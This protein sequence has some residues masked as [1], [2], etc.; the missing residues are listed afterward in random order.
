MKYT[1]INKKFTTLVA[2]YLAK[3]YMINTATMPGS[4]GERAKVDLTNGTEVIR[5]VLES[6]T[7]YD[8]IH[9]RG[10]KIVVGRAGE[11]DCITPNSPE[12]ACTLWNG[13]LEVLYE[14]CFYQIGR[15]G[16]NFGTKEEA[17]VA[18]QK[19]IERWSK[20]P[21]MSNTEYN[22]IDNPEA[23]HIAAQ[24]LLNKGVAKRIDRNSLKL[25]KRVYKKTH[26]TYLVEYKGKAYSLN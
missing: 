15:R 19:S 18:A 3:G 5:I 2:G 21:T 10:W 6:F 1:E 24:Y 11:Q 20:K 9:L 4:Q 12:D 8:D 7:T 17:E 25:R 23:L 22:T 26:V 14:E 16:N 13:H